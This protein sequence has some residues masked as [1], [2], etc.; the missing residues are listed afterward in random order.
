[1]PDSNARPARVAG[2]K[3]PRRVVVLLIAVLTAV[4][5]AGIPQA[6][7][8]ADPPTLVVGSDGPAKFWTGKARSDGRP[9]PGVPG[10]QTVHCD[11][12]ELKVKLPSGTWKRPGGV[13]VA[14]RWNGATE[15]AL[16]LYVYKDGLLVTKSTAA[17]GVA[18]SVIIPSAK[19]GS[20]NV[21]VSYGIT[22]GAVDP[23]AVVSYEGLAEVEYKPAVAPLRDMLP[24]LQSMPQ[25]N[26][27]YDNPGAIF[28]DVA[29]PGQSCYDSERAEQGAV[30]CLRFDQVLKNVGQGPL[31][32][33]FSRQAGTLQDEDVSQRVYR[34][35]D[36]FY[37]LPAGQV[38]FHPVHGHYHFKGFAQSKL[39]LSD[40]AGH[41]VGDAPAA[42]GD[43]VSF[44]ISDT[45]LIAWGQ[46]GDAPLSYPAPDCLEPKQTVGTT[47]YF[48]YGMSRG[49]ADRYNWY[50]PDQ[51][52]DT[53]GISDGT[54]VLFTRVDP[55]N[56]LREGNETNNCGSVIIVLAG[57]QTG[58]PHAD[59]RG[60]G[61]ACPS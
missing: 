7:Q 39:W 55:D 34:S 28:G 38:E 19:N 8:A 57:L 10:C 17:V 2:A 27:T 51:M 14:I 22:Y 33:R 61:P 49:W 20:Y 16:G 53:N 5:L 15:A 35:D 56:K 44:C 25:E 13:Q 24:D 42:V 41:L 1:M 54:Y 9:T 36:T 4:G 48:W 58:Q 59:L 45:D 12:L 32:L 40:G 50:L 30:Q 37:D 23:D 52:I 21:Y 6:A 3:R 43:K 47:E 46:K 26:V 11:K 31:E 18:Q 29:Q 60:A